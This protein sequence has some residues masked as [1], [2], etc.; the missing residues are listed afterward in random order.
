MHLVFRIM[1]IQPIIEKQQ[2][3]DSIELKSSTVTS[4]IFCAKLS[5]AFDGQT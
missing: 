5:A 4:M 2:E 3:N 1:N